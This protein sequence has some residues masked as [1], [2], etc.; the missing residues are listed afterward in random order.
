MENEDTR[1]ENQKTYDA[2]KKEA[3]KFTG[4]KALFWSGRM[5]IIIGLLKVCYPTQLSDYL[6]LLFMVQTE[7]DNEIISRAFKKEANKLNGE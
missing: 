3:A 7:Y 5:S 2:W 4:E 6:E 1:S